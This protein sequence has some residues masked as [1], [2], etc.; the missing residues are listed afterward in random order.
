MVKF[1]LVFRCVT[2]ANY[3][4]LLN[5]DHIMKETIIHKLKYIMTTTSSIKSALF[6]KTTSY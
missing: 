1:K 2:L 3:A 5:L 4:L 6:S